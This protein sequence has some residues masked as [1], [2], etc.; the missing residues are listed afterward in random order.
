MERTQSCL[1]QGQA[2]LRI[3]SAVGLLAMVVLS[4]SIF[5]RLAAAPPPEVEMAGYATSLIGRSRSQRHNA[6][7]SAEQLNGKIVPAGATFSFAKAVQSW[8]VDRGYVK[9]P[10]SF[11]GELVR[12]F[13]GGVCQTSST[14]YNAALLSGMEILERHSHDF[15]AHYVPPGQDAAVAFPSLDLRFR[16]PYRWPVRIVAATK[17][18]RLQVR[19]LGAQKPELQYHVTTE[20]LQRTLPSRL[21]GHGPSDTGSYLRSPGAVGCRVVAYRIGLRGGHAVRRERLSDDTYRAMD[22]VVV[23]GD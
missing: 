3:A 5:G 6:R 17:G 21:A 12:A 13:G 14:L 23:A 10:V 2:A 4:G 7:L 9:A 16:N 8:S 19:I 15:T 22:R 1:R 11:D 18:E 20:T